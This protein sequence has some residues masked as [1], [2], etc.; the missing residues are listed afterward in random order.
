MSLS[1]RSLAQ[2]VDSKNRLFSINDDEDDPSVITSGTRRAENPS[3]II[4]VDE[5]NTSH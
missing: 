1:Q 5:D 2:R 4:E 3:V